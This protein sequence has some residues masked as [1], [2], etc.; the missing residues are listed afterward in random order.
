MQISS[1][2]CLTA[3]LSF[4]AAGAVIATPMSAPAPQQEPSHPL[5]RNQQV[6]LAALAAPLT[7]HSPANIPRAVHVLAQVS[8]ALQS[9]KTANATSATP[10]SP[11]VA[12]MKVAQPAAAT[13]IP[14]QAN[15]AQTG[16]VTTPD[17]ETADAPGA[18]AGQS[19]TPR[20]AAV[21]AFDPA[22]V[23]NVLA[24]AA[25]LAIDSFIAVPA[26]VIEATAFNVDTFLLD[27]A[28]LNP[29]AFTDFLTQESDTIQQLGQ[30][31]A[32]IIG[33]D[34]QQLQDSI[35][36]LSGVTAAKMV[37]KPGATATSPVSGA[38][39]KT[40]AKEQ[41]GLDAGSRGVVTGKHSQDVSAKPAKVTAPG[42]KDETTPAKQSGT[43]TKDQSTSKT[44][45]ATKRDATKDDT[46][47]GDATT[48][49]GQSTS[50]STSNEHSNAV[51]A[52][53]NKATKD[54]GTTKTNSSTHTPSRTPSHVASSGAKH[55]GVSGAKGGNNGNGGGKGRH[56]K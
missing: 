3:G 34:V 25:Q 15:A 48:P 10:A 30:V 37:T 29:N 39:D 53:V 16:V 27:A 11:S 23:A 40:T 13:A 45:G 1:R 8:R 51:S 19:L 2:S 24:S 50:T 56:R 4:V 46:S 55:S 42:Q 5:V 35:G 43:E 49:S 12:R 44:T 31:A 22:G 33:D 41:Q 47:K 28:T 21:N 26:G 18:T 17:P 36:D 54:K 6:Q 7:A 52:P 32:G 38:V 20:S 14:S 9:A